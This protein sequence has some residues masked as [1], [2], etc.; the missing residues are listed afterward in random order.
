MN[1]NTTNLMAAYAVDQGVIGP[2]G[3]ERIR[4]GKRHLYR[5]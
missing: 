5:Y 3:A 1:D 4:Q 2:N